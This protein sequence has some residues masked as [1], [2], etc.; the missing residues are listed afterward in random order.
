[1]KRLRIICEIGCLALY[2]FGG[3]K[4]LHEERSHL[5]G[6]HV[7]ITTMPLVI[8]IAFLGMEI[9]ELRGNISA[10]RKLLENTLSTAG[11]GS[12]KEDN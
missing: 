6:G 8:L 3:W 5:D 11:A 9:S 12:S 4:L 10:L 2:F 7:F 1:M